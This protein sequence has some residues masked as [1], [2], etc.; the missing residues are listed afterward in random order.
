MGEEEDAAA[1]QTVDAA[2]ALM[3]KHEIWKFR[4]R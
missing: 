2:D 4:Q 3:P 1:W